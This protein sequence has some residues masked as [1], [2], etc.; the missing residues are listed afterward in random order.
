MVSGG[1]TLSSTA[2]F[3]FQQI[4]VSLSM[5]TRWQ[6]GRTSSLST[7]QM[8]PPTM[9]EAHSPAAKD[10]RSFEVEH[11]QRHCAMGSFLEGH[12]QVCIYINSLDKVRRRAQ[13]CS[14]QK[15]QHQTN[16]NG[17]CAP[18]LLAV[19]LSV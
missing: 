17:C 9:S 13:Q 10:A 5:Q 6:C 8:T 19:A 11:C 3:D 1:H 7:H 2:L 15:F 4:P 12:Q 16:V 14:V 18:G